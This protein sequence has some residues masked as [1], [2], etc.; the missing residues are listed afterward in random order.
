MANGFKRMRYRLE[1]GIL[2]AFG[3]LVRWLPY[4]AS[5]W[6]SARFA[7]MVGGMTRG[8]AIASRNMAIAFR[9]L[10]PEAHA[11]LI[12][13][14]WHHMGKLFT[15]FN[16]IQQILAQPDY[17]MTVH[18]SHHIE[19]AKQLGKPILLV[20]GHF[21]N[22]EVTSLVANLTNI[23]PHYIYRSINNPYIDEWAKRRRA[24]HKAEFHPKS[25]DTAKLLVRSFKQKQDNGIL[26]DQKLGTGG[27][28]VPFFGKPCLTATSSIELA[29]RNDYQI[30]LCHS[31]RH[32][33]GF[34]KPPHFTIQ[35]EALPPEPTLTTIET[36]HN[37][38]ETWIKA[39]PE[40]WFWFHDRWSG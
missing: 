26:I 39:N 21:G 33:R 34:F 35:L 19:E 1:A 36:I 37:R 5:A 24:Y 10:S 30:I 38:L 13:Q 32:D 22:W 23:K 28:W 20:S 40:Q 16:R 3:L 7:A 2:F 25:S 15:D 6:L 4:G 27:T 31:V 14:C 8:Q 18:G 17:F 11:Q 9:D 12:R 29:L